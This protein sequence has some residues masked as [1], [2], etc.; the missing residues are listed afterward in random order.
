MKL[1]HYVGTKYGQDIRNELNRKVKVKLVTSVH[2]NEVLLRHATWEAMV[3][4]E[5]FNIQEALR[6][7]AIMLRSSATS[8][9][10]DAELPTKISIMDNEITKGD[11]N[12]AKKI[13]IEMSE[14]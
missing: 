2:L 4:T 9:T 6:A 12:L 7:Q 8:D 11:Y 1:V 13:S 14:S 5:K 3:R 10:S